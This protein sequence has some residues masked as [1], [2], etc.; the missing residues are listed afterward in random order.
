MAGVLE[1]VP[2]SDAELFEAEGFY[3]VYGRGMGM[4]RNA[5]LIW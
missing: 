2:S 4:A 1:A 5:V 3:G